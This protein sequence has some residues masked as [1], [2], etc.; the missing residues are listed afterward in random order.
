MSIE[1]GL[2]SVVIINFNSKAFIERC[3]AN[4]EQQT[5]AS[6]EILVIDNGSTD[7]SGALVDA[8]AAS[9]RIRCFRGANVGSSKANNLGIRE[10]HGEFVLVLNADAFPDTDYLEKCIGAFRRDPTVGTVIGKLVSDSDPTVIDSAG[11]YFYREGVAVERGFGEKDQGQ[12]DREEFVDGACC[13]AAVYRRSMLETIKIDE[14]FYDEDFFAFAE[15]SD[16][17]FR[18]ALKGWTTLYFPT[19]RVRHVRGGCSGIIKEFPVFLNER[20]TRLFIQ[21]SFCW[22]L[23]PSDRWLQFILFAGRAVTL[24]RY[25]SPS[26][27]TRLSME[28][29]DLGRLMDAKSDRVPPGDRQS[30]FSMSGRKSY[31]VTAILRRI[32]I[33]SRL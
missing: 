9:G 26:M 27:R 24:R 16:L 1:A 5:W 17:S 20:N 31:V 23:R 12:F 19:A 28:V 4:I 11:V 22:V 21:K 32:G 30:A 33:S 14:E 18:S 13:A 25:L 8:M 2:V 29:K 3:I 15:D 6:R 10:G 7:G